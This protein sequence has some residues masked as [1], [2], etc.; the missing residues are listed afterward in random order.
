MKLI[1]GDGNQKWAGYIG[2]MLTSGE[3][4]QEQGNGTAS[5][6]YGYTSEYTVK[7]HQMEDPYVSVY[8]NFTS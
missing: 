5:S 7:T 8:I 4:R 2:C 3:H 6:G 1:I